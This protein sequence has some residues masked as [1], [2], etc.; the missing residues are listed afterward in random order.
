MRIIGCVLVIGICMMIGRTLA[1]GYAARV[2]NL[3]TFITALSILRTKIGYGQEIL[4]LA[5]NDI[6]LAIGGIVGKMFLDISD[7][8]SRSNI[9]VS[10]IWSNKLEEH[11]KYFDF[12]FEDERILIDFGSRL[13]KGDIDEEIRNINLASERLKTQLIIANEEKNKYAKLYKTLGGVGGTA[14]AVI[15]I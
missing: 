1:G 3:Q 15:L 6:G 7:E 11:F 2:N 8:L 14:L 13:G 9:L 4:E 12:N 5:F 10:E